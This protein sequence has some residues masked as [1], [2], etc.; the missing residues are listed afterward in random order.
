[1]KNSCCRQIQSLSVQLVFILGM[2]A[3][4]FGQL[5]ERK[6]ERDASGLYKGRIHGGS[7]LFTYPDSPPDGPYITEPY[8]GKLKV[9][10]KDG[11]L[12]TR[13]VNPALPGNGRAA[14]SGKEQKSDVKRG[15]KKIAFK[16]KGTATDDDPD[17]GIWQGGKVGG[18]FSDKG[19]KWKAALVASGVKSVAG[20]GV[21]NEPGY[22]PQYT[23]TM[24]GLR[25]NG[26]D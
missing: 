6:I 12:K 18:S 26:A 3:T 11:K 19:S 16:A 20:K 24:T 1:M 2:S 17:G 4:A 13:M 22:V 7:L 14:L 25:F 9:P 15:G 21:L 10:V 8:A 5:N 23:S